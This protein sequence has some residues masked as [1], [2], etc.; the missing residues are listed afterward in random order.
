MPPIFLSTRV[1]IMISAAQPY[2]ASFLKAVIKIQSYIRKMLT[3]RK[4]RVS[5]IGPGIVNIHLNTSS[6]S[7]IFGSA[8]SWLDR[9][10]PHEIMITTINTDKTSLELVTN[11]GSP[12]HFLKYLSTQKAGYGAVIN[13]GFYDF[14]S[15][16]K[17]PINMPIGL[18]KFN[19][20]YLPKAKVR[21]FTK[22]VDNLG[23][24]LEHDKTTV[25]DGKKSY[26]SGVETKLN[27][28]M[29]VP[30]SYQAD[31]AAIT[32]SHENHVEITSYNELYKSKEAF[33]NK[34][35]ESK[36]V[37][38][39]GPILI[40]DTKIVFTEDRLALPEYQFE[41]LKKLGKTHPGELPPGTFYH[42]DQPNPRAA[43][44]KISDNQVMMI[45]VKG[46]EDPHKRDGLTLSDFAKL[47]NYFKPRVAVNLDG[48]FSAFQGVFDSRTMY[49][50]DFIKQCGNGRLV[51]CSLVATAA[52]RIDQETSKENAE[53][54][55]LSRDSDH[56]SYRAI[57]KANNL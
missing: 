5:S 39:S 2:S 10:N 23:C 31:Y 47:I 41:T 3:Q 43:F 56:T 34:L 53:P 14:G 46:E 13:G 19:L 15:F 48:G 40:S 36:S 50:P 12:D 52:P 27:K 51:P 35:S 55:Q 24:F 8:Y 33:E 9:E 17:L 11:Q 44:A 4:V 21:R 20:N 26:G 25:T 7:E 30:H 18:H 22:N 49:T 37:L 45:S 54:K 1:L 6:L 42:A 38:S 16:Y 57:V 32:I 29:Q 28:K